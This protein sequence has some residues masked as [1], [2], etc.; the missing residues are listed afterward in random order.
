MSTNRAAEWRRTALSGYIVI[1]LTFGLAGGWTAVAEIDQAVV[2][3]GVVSV[4]TNRKT[5]QHFEGGIVKEIRAREGDVVR[6]GDVLFELE[7]LQAEAN[8][9]VLRRELVSGLALEA[10]FVAE[11]D[12]AEDISWPAEI[13][14]SDAEIARLISDQTRQFTERRK[15]LLGQVSILESKI[16]QLESDIKGIEIEKTSTEQQRVLIDR[17]LSGLRGLLASQL[18]TATRVYSMERERVR[19]EGVSG[20]LISEAAKANGGVAEVRVQIKQLQQKFHE[21]VASGLLDAR[22]KNA[23]VRRKLS[24]ASDILRRVSIVAPCSGTIQNLR[25]F[26]VGQVIHS[27]EALLDIV[28]ID[29]PLIVQAHFSPTDIDSVHVGQMTEIRFPAFHSRTLPLMTGTLR[30]LSQDRLIDDTTKAPYY[31][32]VIA[33]ARADL[34]DVLRSRLRSGMPAD[35]IVKAGERTVLQ[36]IV[37]PLSSSMR[38]TFIEK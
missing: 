19:L 34:P 18:V 20:K 30:S 4:E 12:G 29:E 25:V 7:R 38:K 2:A 1:I 21:D 31:L 6:E 23:E 33:V 9:D 3:S 24:V 17:E 35:V 11:R 13:D 10:R 14:R 26:T 32:G 5:A 37:S 27:G 36:Y 22:Q 28:P 16:D 8:T 15:S